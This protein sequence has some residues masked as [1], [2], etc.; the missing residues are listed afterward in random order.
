MESWALIDGFGRT[1]ATLAEDTVVSVEGDN[2]TEPAQRW[3]VSGY[4]SGTPKARFAAST[5]NTTP[6]VV[7]SSSTSQQLLLGPTGA[8]VTTHSGDNYKPTT[9]TGL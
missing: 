9:W 3:I 6:S 5:S 8:N 1:I 4:R 7:R 2:G